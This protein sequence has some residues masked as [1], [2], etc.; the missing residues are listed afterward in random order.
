M[1]KKSK[2][3]IIYLGKD[4]VLKEIK[5]LNSILD[6]SIDDTFVKVVNTILETKGRII[7]SGMGKAG[8]V[9]HKFSATLA[10]TG[11]PA[12]FIHPGE[13][14]HGDLGMITKNDTV[15]LISGSG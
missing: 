6:S 14:S 8:Y 9:A 11:T 2:S 5:G 10:S 1:I 13:A 15:I 3:D 12:L 4:A 7:V